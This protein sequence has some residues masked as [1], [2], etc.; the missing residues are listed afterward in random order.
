[1][2]RSVL[3][4]VMA[5]VVCTLA[6]CGTKPAPDFRG[7]W[8]AV[9]EVD[10]A[11][12]AIPLQPVQRFLVLPSDRTLKGVVDRWA[13]ESGRRSAYRASTDFSL[14]IDAAKVSASNLDTAVAQLSAAYAAQGIRIDVQPTSIV[15]SL[16]GVARGPDTGTAAAPAAGADLD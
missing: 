8:K 2:T 13:K 15:V 14:H 3:I 11:P 4:A 16:G 9:N 1:M 7:R 12:R 5:L 10:A 6:A